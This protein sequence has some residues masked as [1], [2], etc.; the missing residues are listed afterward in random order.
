VKTGLRCNN[1]TAIAA[2]DEL[3][4]R[5]FIE[6]VDESFFCSR[7]ESKSRTWRLTWMPFN[8]QFPTMEWEEYESAIKSTG[9]VSAPE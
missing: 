4:E 2:F 1:R 8:H 9:V 7:T 3:Q 5:R 6:M